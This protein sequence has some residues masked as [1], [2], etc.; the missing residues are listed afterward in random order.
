M[1]FKENFDLEYCTISQDDDNDNSLM[2]K[3]EFFSTEEEYTKALMIN[4]EPNL[5]SFKQEDLSKHESNQL[6]KDKY[7]HNIKSKLRSHISNTL[8]RVKARSWISSRYRLQTAKSQHDQ[9]CEF[10]KVAVSQTRTSNEKTYR[11]IKIKNI[12]HM[13]NSEQL[14]ES[15]YNSL[16]QLK[17]SKAKDQIH[18][19]E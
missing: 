6:C 13:S 4:D 17:N 11:S 3:V 15:T 8:N 19:D 18:N 1:T 14:E 2:L 5:N 16:E 9:I 7:I 10:I 12:D